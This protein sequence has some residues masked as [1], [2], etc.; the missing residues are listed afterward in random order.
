MFQAVFEKLDKLIGINSS[1]FI[2]WNTSA[3]KFEFRGNVVFNASAQ[4]LRIYLDH[5]STI[6]PYLE[7]GSHLGTPLNA[8]VKITDF[9]PVSRYVETRYAREF[10]PLIPC[11]YEMNAMIGCQGD[12]IGAIALHRKPRERDFKERDRTIMN[13][14][15]P[16]LARALH[17]IALMETIASSQQ[18]GIVVVGAEGHPI[19]MNQ[20]AHRI[21]NGRPVGLIPEPGNGPDPAFFTTEAGVYRVRTVPVQWGGPEKIIFLERQPPEMEINARLSDLHLTRRKGEIAVLVIRGLSN[22]EIAERL[23]I[24]EQTVKDHLRDVFE[25]LR[26]RHRSE[27]ASKVFGLHPASIA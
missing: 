2:P 26:I 12:P 27:L 5:F 25:K 18:A 20:E 22:R 4:T 16:H 17:H 15:L 11:F 8:S 19:F 13:L 6:D 21:L 9:M 23:F 3:S 14:L 24:E 7:T 10:A 1:A